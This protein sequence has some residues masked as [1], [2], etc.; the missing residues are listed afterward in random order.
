MQPCAAQSCV[1]IAS[2]RIASARRQSDECVTFGVCVVL[3][4]MLTV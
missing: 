2:I 1:L 3:C 4:S